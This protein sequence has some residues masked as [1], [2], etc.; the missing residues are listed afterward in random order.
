[1]ITVREHALAQFGRDNIS[2]GTPMA[3]LELV[4]VPLYLGHRYQAEAVS[5]II[6][7]ID[8]SYAVK[9]S[10]QEEKTKM[11]DPQLQDAAI[12]VLLKT[13]DPDFLTLPE[14]IINLIPPVPMGYR[15]G[16]EHFKI[17]TGISFDPITAAEVAAGTTLGFMLNPERMSRLFEQHARNSS[18]LSVASYFDQIATELSGF[19][20]K[21][22][23]LQKTIA[24]VVEAQFI[25]YLIKLAADQSCHHQ[26]RGLARRKLLEYLQGVPGASS[27]HSMAVLAMIDQF[28]SDP[29]KY[30]EPLVLP[31]PDGSPIGC[32]FHF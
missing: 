16:R 15:R 24:E 5:K 6:A 32:S 13:L 12:A 7:G 23:N 17:R 14:S 2:D 29:A 11:V 21:T 27:G 22:T 28:I 30:Q 25:Q 18:R 9:G 20:R 19:S 31:M 3:E 4:L 10:G 26:V 8:Y 1:M